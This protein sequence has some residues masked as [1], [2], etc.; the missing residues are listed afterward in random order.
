[1]M[2]WEREISKYL[3]FLAYLSVKNYSQVQ[4]TVKHLH[5]DIESE[6]S[7]LNVGFG[8]GIVCIHNLS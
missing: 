8:L 6:F 3:I 4:E 5:E 2:G 1:M 7:V